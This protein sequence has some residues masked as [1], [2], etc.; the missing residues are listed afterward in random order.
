MIKE[1]PYAIRKDLIWTMC[2]DHMGIAIS[3]LNYLDDRVKN[4]TLSEGEFVAE[5]ERLLFS[6]E[7][8]LDTAGRRGMPRLKLFKEVISRRQDLHPDVVGRLRTIMDR[9]A[10][11]DIVKLEDEFVVM[12]DNTINSPNTLEGI[13]FLLANGL[14]LLDPDC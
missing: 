13:E 7:L 6:K 9:V 14:L 5:I 3:I 10:M 8:L 4:L 12:G 1:S 2:A 11:G